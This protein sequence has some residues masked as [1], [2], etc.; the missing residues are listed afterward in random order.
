MKIKYDFAVSEV[1]GET[2]AISTAPNRPSTVVTLNSTARFMWELL[3]NGTDIDTM[4][5]ALV[6]R[7]DGLDQDT[8]HAEAEEFVE[9]LRS[10][11]LLDE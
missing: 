3:A 10:N 5:G 1:A 4:A 7:Y 8:A 2:I 6:E 9:L 11:Q